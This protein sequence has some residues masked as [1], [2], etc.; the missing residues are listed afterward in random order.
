[1]KKIEPGAT[2]KSSELNMRFFGQRLYMK[3]FSLIINFYDGPDV[4]PFIHT[5]M[6]I[7]PK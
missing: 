6:Y 2:Q 5:L 1:M 3:V 7:K 4:T